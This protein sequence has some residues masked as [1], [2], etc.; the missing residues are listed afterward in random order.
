[1]FKIRLE[2][3]SGEFVS[4]AWILPATPVPGVVVWGMRVFVLHLDPEEPAGVPVYREAFTVAAFNENATGR[5][6][7]SPP[8]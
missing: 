5:D 4:D 7:T 6:Q 3:A 8:A 1:M 2:L